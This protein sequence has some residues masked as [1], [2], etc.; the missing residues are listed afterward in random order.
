MGKIRINSEELKYMTLF[1]TMTGATIKDCVQEEES[2][3]F[4]VK[5]G[6]MGFSSISKN[7]YGD[8]KYWKLIASANL[9][10]DSTRLRPGQKV[11]CPD[12]PVL[13]AGA[14]VTPARTESARVGSTTIAPSAVGAGAPTRTKL[15]GGRV[16]D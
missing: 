3:G 16:F 11:L 10:L 8:E 9:G 6:D 4:V 7:V 1:E 15:P 12:K 14:A 13:S 2:I 5:K